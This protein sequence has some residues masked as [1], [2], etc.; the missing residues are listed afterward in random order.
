[1][2]DK[3]TEHIFKEEPWVR[4]LLETSWQNDL[5]SVD[6]GSMRRVGNFHNFWF[7]VR[8]LWKRRQFIIAQ[9]RAKAHVSVK[10][11][12]LGRLWLILEPFI[13]SAIYYFIFALL[14][15]FDRGMD[16]FVGYLVIGV[17][18]FNYLNQQLGAAGSIIPAGMNLIRAFPFP[19][20]ALVFAFSVRN[21]IDFFPTAIATFLFVLVF[22][23]H[24]FPTWTWLLAVPVFFIAVIFGTGLSFFASA[25]TVLLPDL[26]FIWPVLTRFWF[27]GS[28]VFW[29]IDM[30]ADK[31]QYQAIMTAN[32][33]WTYLEMMRETILYGQVP[34]VNLWLYLGTW[35][36]FTFLTG[37][38]FF[39]RCEGYLG[40]KND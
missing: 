35:A 10:G 33:G 27:Y 2:S 23:P 12:F 20:A 13:S 22:P 8:G 39:W 5:V 17:T 16:N 38:L 7:Y 25:L 29:S 11:T 14:L 24:T 3:M 40:K 36:V 28:G 30:F 1:M 37:F 9:S 32:P 31:P 19:R 21:V 15:G 4:V 18:F 6:L 34:G 26:K